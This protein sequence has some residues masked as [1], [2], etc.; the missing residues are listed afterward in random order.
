MPDRLDRE[1]RLHKRPEVRSALAAIMLGL[2]VGCSANGSGE[3]PS[4]P[5]QDGGPVMVGSRPVELIWSTEPPPLTGNKLVGFP[6]RWSNGH[7]WGL[8]RGPLSDD[9]LGSFLCSASGDIV[10]QLGTDNT[11]RLGDITDAVSH[12]VKVLDRCDHRRVLVVYIVTYVLQPLEESGL[13]R[14]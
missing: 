1:S 11:M 13:D 12:L 5:R 8:L 9:E 6:M 14:R 3:A 10:V 2:A 4:I 7:F